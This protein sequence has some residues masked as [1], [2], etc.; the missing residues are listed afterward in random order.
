MDVLLPWLGRLLFV[1]VINAFN[2]EEWVSASSASIITHNKPNAT[3]LHNTQ[4]LPSDVHAA[5]RLAM[6]HHPFPSVRRRRRATAFPPLLAAT[7]LLLLLCSNVEAMRRPFSSLGNSSGNTR[8]SLAVEEQEAEGFRRLAARGLAADA[9]SP[10]AHLVMD[11]PGL[12]AGAFPT[13]HWA[14]LLTV[15]EAIE[16]KYFYWFVEA[17]EDAANK[18]LLIWLNGGPGCSSMDGFFLENG[19]F[20]V[21]E[22][23]SIKVHPHSWHHVANVLY[24][25][26]P[27]GTGFTFTGRRQYCNDDACINGHMYSFLQSFSK[28]HKDLVFPPGGDNSKTKPIFFS[29]ESQAGH[30][31]PTMVDH[32]MQ[33]NKKVAAGAATLDVQGM[34]IGNGWIDPSN[35]YDVSQFAH[36]AGLI[37][38]GQR[39]TLLKKRGD[40]N[41]LLAKGHYFSP[42]CF[43]LLDE[44]VAATGTESS[45]FVSLYDYRNFDNPGHRVFPP[46][47]EL[48]EKYMNQAAVKDALHASESPLT[49]QECTDPPYDHLKSQDGLGVTNEVTRILEGGVRALFFNGAFDIICN[50]VG[51]E[52]LLQGLVWSGQKDF[53]AASRAVWLPVGGGAAG[54]GRPGGYAKSSGLL[55]YLVVAGAGHMVPLDVPAAALDMIGRFLNN[56][57][58]A[59]KPQGIAM[60]VAPPV[61]AAP[62]AGAVATGAGEVVVKP[63]PTPKLKGVKASSTKEGTV[64]LDI[65]G[66]AGQEGGAQQTDE[67]WYSVLVNPGGSLLVPQAEGGAESGPLLL[68]DMKEGVEYSFQVMSNNIGGASKPS[69]SLK[70]LLG[71]AAGGEGGA[72]GPNTTLCQHGMCGFD[73]VGNDKRCF[74]YQGWDGPSCDVALPAGSGMAPAKEGGDKEA[75]VGRGGRVTFVVD[76]SCAGADLPQECALRFTVPLHLCVDTKEGGKEAGGEGEAWS[77]L[78]GEEETRA[79]EGMLRRDLAHALNIHKEQILMRSLHPLNSSSS[80]VTEG[81]NLLVVDDD[82]ATAALPSTLPHTHATQPQP[83]ALTFDL[84]YAPDPPSTVRLFTSLWSAPKGPLSFGLVT[85]NF[86]VSHNAEVLLLARDTPLADGSGSSSSSSGSGVV[87]VSRPAKR[88]L[89]VSLAACLLVGMLLLMVVRYSRRKLGMGGGSSSSSGGGGGG[90]RVRD[91]GR[92]RAHLDDDIDRDIVLDGSDDED[93][94]GGVIEIMEVRSSHTGSLGGGGGGSSSSSSSRGGSVTRL[95]GLGLGGSGGVGS[96]SATVDDGADERLV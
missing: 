32:I 62:A 79:F 42:V 55:T 65:E 24:I 48:V 66:V 4:V 95:A 71:C 87:V 10:D 19:P 25:D 91:G 80:S 18:P 30:Y 53:H 16:G 44:V 11:L 46:G 76:Q 94:E 69:E 15:D 27:V 64:E 21:Q 85:S 35:Q 63:P 90:G 14:G 57:S 54:E 36:G 96:R 52:A 67:L 12:A 41:A 3:R 81:G 73:A 31:I 40:C 89:T 45:G 43:S 9:T 39:N 58:F 22:D 51:N 37:S 33:Q 17:A 92:R 50:H 49:F 34:A 88:S 23:M 47:H 82:D 38:E 2:T 61:A 56:K 29:G 72:A 83:M 86:D 68:T 60:S 75:A 26:Q 13:R 84:L 93:G 77:V 78:D 7:A 74:C 5:P 1:A 8:R 20:K 59:D 6:P 28:L 70:V